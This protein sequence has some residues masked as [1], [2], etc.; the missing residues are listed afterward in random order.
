MVGGGHGHACRGHMVGGVTSYLLLAFST[1][2]DLTVKDQLH[3]HITKNISQ[4]KLWVNC[5]ER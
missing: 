3:L 5:L 1:K 2:Q 4:E